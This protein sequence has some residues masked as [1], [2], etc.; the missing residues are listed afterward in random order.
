M[1]ATD[2][3]YRSQKTLDIVFAVSSVLMLASIFW[4]LYQDYSREFKQVQ[5]KFR[6]VEDE[7][8][9][10][11]MADKLP[12]SDRIQ[13]IEKAEA[14][15]AKAKEEMKD[16]QS[17]HAG[18]V[19]K[20]KGAY[21]AADADARAIKADYDSISSLINIAQDEADHADA[22]RRDTLL[23]RVADLKTQA[24]I[25]KAKLGAAVQ[26]K[27]DARKAVDQAE[28]ELK[29][30]E[31][32]KAQ[33]IAS[34]MF[35]TGLMDYSAGQAETLGQV[36]DNLHKVTAEFDRLA[37]TAALKKW[38]AGDW[39]RKLP[40]I[41]GFASPTKIQQFTL[42]DLTIDYSF[43]Q[44][45]RFDR[46]M[47][48]HQ[49][50]DRANFDK[51]ALAGLKETPD[52]LAKRLSE[53]HALLA[54][55]LKRGENLGFDPNDIPA[56]L[57]AI[58][59]NSG[60]ITQYC[61]H[62]RLELFVDAN[63]PHPVEKFGCTICHAGQGSA[64]DF[65]NAAHT[66]NSAHQKEEW[67]KNH[68]WE[69]GEFWDYPMLPK[70]FTESG[71]LKCHHMVTDL[72]RYGSKEEAPKLLH[73]FNL[74]RENGCFGCHEIA[75][76]KSGRPVGPDLRLEANVLPLEA[77]TAAERAV[78]QADPLNPPGTM[79][80]VGPSLYHLGEKTN[81]EWVRKWLA[82]PRGFRPDTKMP[83][84]FGLSTNNHEY[85]LR[86]G[87]GQENYPNAEIY[88]IAYY[89]MQESKAYL[90]GQ[91]HYRADNL[92]RY[93]KYEA[94]RKREAELRKQ[95]AAEGL[96]EGERSKLQAELLQVVLTEKGKKELEEITNRLKI[97]GRYALLEAVLDGRMTPE[98]AASKPEQDLINTLPTTLAK[99]T[100]SEGNDVTK[101]YSDYARGRNDAKRLAH[102]NRLFREKGCLACHVNDGVKTAGKDEDGR[103][104]PEIKDAEA[105]F[106]PNLSR[107]AAKLGV[108]AGDKT[109]A[110]RWLVQWVLNP[111]VH[112]PRTRMPIT[113]L[114]MEEAS[115]LA[116]WLL[117]QSTDWTAED[118]PAPSAETLKRLVRLNLLAPKI[119]TPEEVDK[120]L[121]NGY[122]EDQLKNM[123]WDA[124]E[125]VLA[126]M[127]EPN[128]LWYVGKRAVNRLG[129][130]GCHNV[131]GFEAAKPIGTPLNDWGKKD[132]E[133][134]AFEDIAA[135]LDNQIAEKKIVVVDSFN[136]KL[137][138]LN[139]GQQAYEKLFLDA[140]KGHH[141]EGF[142]H[143]KLME[144]RSYDY[145]RP[146]DYD[147]RLRMPQFRFARGAAVKPRG[148]ETR[149]QAE[150]RAEAEAREAVMTFVLG[151][152]AEPIPFQYLNRPTGDKLAE[153][154]GRAV[155]DTFNCAGC[156]QI[157]AGVYEFKRYESKQPDTN[158]SPLDKL[159]VRAKEADYSK[160]HFFADHNAWVGG[161]QPVDRIRMHGIGQ[162]SGENEL[163]VNLTQALRFEESLPPDQSIR[164]GES[165]REMPASGPDLIHASEPYGGYLSNLLTPYLMGRGNDTWNSDYRARHGLPPTLIREGERVQ[166]DWLFRFLRRPTIV[167]PQF[168][169][170]GA[171]EKG[172]M[173][174]RMPR[175]NMSDDDAQAIVNYFAAVDRQ[176]NPAFG[177]NYPYLAYPQRR[178]NYLRE[179]NAQYA[180]ELPKLR[181]EVEKSVLPALEAAAKS[182]KEAEDK[183]PPDQ[184]AAATK[185]REDADK[186]LAGVKKML[187]GVS[188]KMKSPDAFAVDA[189]HLLVAG[190]AGAC[191]QCHNV[192]PL[193]AKPSPYGPPLDIVYDRLRPE[194]MERWL[195]N[196]QRLLSYQSFMPANYPRVP[197][198]DQ[199]KDQNL[200][201]GDARSHLTAL[202]DLLMIYPK[203]A[204][205][206]EN[207]DFRPQQ[208]AGGTKP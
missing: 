129:C 204:A 136:G 62:P 86:E 156:H 30:E 24:D 186:E 201:P 58:A 166:P 105:D 66:P 163:T 95:L 187:E 20:A 125:R 152:V 117:S 11:A 72:V 90:K 184:K 113:H 32:G 48:C 96:D 173:A 197:S 31:R 195:A 55:R 182:A 123:R 124:D 191:L 23:K 68:E 104:L 25:L 135:F 2:Q 84:F 89:L 200:M 175:F 167:R 41:D 196:P 79:R 128:M 63:S 15:L 81:E 170:Q 188:D 61:A 106:G 54:A 157:R 13:A 29:D 43:K 4:M 138:E 115:D 193:E 14:D 151:L 121:A 174:L 8:F 164:A 118:V 122:T 56:K 120:I 133:R 126:K 64:T 150:A 148:E 102:G 205:L 76:I 69:H 92:E 181:A 189:Y 39:F 147:A 140:I 160:D 53:A 38:K 59:L 155:L 207:R 172:M 145:H 45:T 1:A 87:T 88:A 154:K 34:Y 83:H 67:E 176:D 5:R 3:N 149:E 183:A 52:E 12:A 80:K 143:Q 17:R 171:I 198:L 190:R 130:F 107:L 144:P 44:V 94:D 60:E 177:V 70:R 132:P 168:S 158:P 101:A 71:C 78:A 37:K 165:V 40:L 6:D 202:R 65:V 192:G 206:P 194:W 114:N 97:A 47:T 9:L 73:G 100:D 22:G 16:A 93:K 162:K 99:L 169:R 51:D 10:R 137:P 139:E 91:D 49:G 178:D 77:L 179:R 19:R 127:D 33:A 36:E 18:N 112:H 199:E 74:I 110:H 108:T 26:K 57:D 35:S 116:D 109:S 103:N 159:R 21:E 85:L 141:R 27:E 111:K 161:P 203:A 134:L 131:P 185:A 50:V 142:L 153:A 42:N 75:G 46:C 180:A 98:E 28:N 208:P 119:L 146:L 7:V 82:S